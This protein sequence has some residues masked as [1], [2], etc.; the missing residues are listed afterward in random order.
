[1]SKSNQ[2]KKNVTVLGAE[3]EFTGVLSFKDNLIVMGSFNGTISAFGNIEISKEAMCVVNSISANSIV[4]SGKVR[5]NINAN[6]FVEMKSG[7]EIQGNIR[8]SKIRIEDDVDFQGKIA[9]ID[10][11]EN[12]DLFEMSSNE[13][14]DSLS[15]YKEQSV[16]NQ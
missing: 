4:V 15:L 12:S 7:S 8:T 1:M 5:G 14:R 2:A 6:E 3:T 9:M 16:D 13:Y 11:A 10:H